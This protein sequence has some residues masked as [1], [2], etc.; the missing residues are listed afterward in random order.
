MQ[1]YRGTTTENGDRSDQSPAV[2]TPDISSTDIENQ[3]FYD[4]L[5]IIDGYKP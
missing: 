2:T 5:R 3:A 4:S 1:G